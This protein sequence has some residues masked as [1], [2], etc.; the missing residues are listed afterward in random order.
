MLDTCHAT[1]KHWHIFYK[2]FKLLKK[3][4]GEKKHCLKKT[5]TFKQ[6][7][8]KN[9]TNFNA[10]LMTQHYVVLAFQINLTALCMRSCCT[11]VPF[12]LCV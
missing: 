5:K 8:V 4:S 7:V 10:I 6:T 2:K 9:A 11:E 12:L 3:K 1:V